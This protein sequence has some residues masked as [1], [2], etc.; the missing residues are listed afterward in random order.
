MITRAR[1]KAN[2][3]TPAGKLVLASDAAKP[4]DSIRERAPGAYHYF[5]VK[6]RS[7]C[8]CVLLPGAIP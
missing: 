7:V 5:C 8:A 3:A 2:I 6:L 4:S 1:L